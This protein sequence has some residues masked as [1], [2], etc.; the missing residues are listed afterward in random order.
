MQPGLRRLGAGATQLTPNRDADGVLADKLAVLTHHADHAL[1]AEPGFD[2]GPALRALSEQAAGEHPEAWTL[3][4]PTTWHARHLG[5][6]IRDDTVTGDGRPAIGDCLRTLP[7]SWRPAALLALAFAEDFAIL[8]GA[9]GRVRWLAVCLPSRWAPEDKIGH[10][11]SQVHA[12]VADNQMLIAASEH[13]I[14]LVTGAERWERFVWTVSPDAR[15]GQHP[16]IGVL[17]PWSASADTDALA[18]AAHFRT[19]RQTF[20]PLPQ[21]RQAVFTIQVESCPLVKAVTSAERADRLHAALASMSP[22]V[23]DYRGLTVARERL[24]R[25]LDERRRTTD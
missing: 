13:L 3:D 24:L 2:A 4:A 6:S 9:T 8:D 22:V 23:L 7:A 10:H 14:R 12:A 1:Q 20:I 11:F 18:A 16:R 5:W 21:L 19:E 17:A 15:R 25:W